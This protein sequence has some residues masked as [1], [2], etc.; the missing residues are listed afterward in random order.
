MGSFD[1]VSFYILR[2]FVYEDVFT[3]VVGIRAVGFPSVFGWQI[4][5][6]LH[7]LDDVCLL[8]YNNLVS[9]LT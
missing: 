1:I 4:V 6:Y 2:D 9:I 5:A 7:V 3:T 8:P